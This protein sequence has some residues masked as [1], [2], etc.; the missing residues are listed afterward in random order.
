MFTDETRSELDELDPI[1]AD[2][3]VGETEEDTDLD[4]DELDDAEEKVESD[5][6]E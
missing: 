5:D 3:E 2:D 4:E 6:T 1:L